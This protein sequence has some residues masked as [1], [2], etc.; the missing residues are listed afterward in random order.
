MRRMFRTV[1]LAVAVALLGGLFSFVGRVSSADP[2]KKETKEPANLTAAAT[3]S[4]LNV[5]PGGSGVVRIVCT[6]R[7]TVHVYSEKFKVMPIA[8]DGVTYGKHE[9]K[10]KTV[11]FTGFPDVSTSVPSLLNL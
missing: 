7:R 4:P 3:V 8:V 10:T 11:P 1:T 9:F 6:V 5:G 2:K